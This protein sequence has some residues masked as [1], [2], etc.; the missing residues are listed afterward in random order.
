MGRD[1]TGPVESPSR[2]RLTVTVS[3]RSTS[4]QVHGVTGIDTLTANTP[5][6][7]LPVHRTDIPSLTTVFSMRPFFVGRTKT[8]PTSGRTTDQTVPVVGLLETPL[9]PLLHPSTMW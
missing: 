5:S 6:V 8:L 2:S 1:E 9:G 3:N 7:P 4:D